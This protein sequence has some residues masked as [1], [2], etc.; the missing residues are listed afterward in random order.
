M[1]FL[2]FISLLAWVAILLFR[3]NFWRADQRLARH[4][5]ELKSWPNVVAVIPARNEAETVF[6]TVSSLI[7]QDYPGEFSIVLVDDGSDDGTA[8]VASK[9]AEGQDRML[10]VVSGKPLA[11]GWTGKLWAVFQGV[12]KADE[13][14]KDFEYILFTDA[15]IEHD[16][17]DLRR[18]VSKAEGENLDMV[19]LMVMLRCRSLWEILLI[20]AFVFFFQKLYPFPW[21]NNPKRKEA[22][23][24]GGCMLVRRT[25]LQRSG[26][27]AAICD[28]LIDD[29][30]LARSIK[31]GGPIWIGLSE[32]ARSLR[33]Y[34][35]LGEIWKMVARTA[36]VQL[37]H[38]IWLLAGSVMGMLV[39]YIAPPAA[40]VWGAVSDNAETALMGLAAFL[41]M[42]TAYGP[43]LKLYARP[44]WSAFLLPVAAF[45]YVFMTLDSA[46]RH[47]QGR[48]GAWKGRSYA[49]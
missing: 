25:A 46:R 28:Q 43:T 26:G 35:G 45:L 17:L 40:L 21:A 13:V 5:C 12:E 6:Q 8:K 29:C 7:G 24:A 9:A 2:A 38:S 27:I 18:L 1:I 48:G 44:L 23:A 39:L 10:S 36:F 20:P 11:E 31:K 42:A 34:E 14:A 47:W 41:L 32:T 19:S 16:S 3:G 4:P 22:A 30:A 49:Q 15:D 33:A 37:N